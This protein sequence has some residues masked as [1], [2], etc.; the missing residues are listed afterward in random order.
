M[1]ADAAPARIGSRDHTNPH[2]AHVGRV[3]E[4]NPLPNMPR[5]S[6]AATYRRSAWLSAVAESVPRWT[7]GEER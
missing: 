6:A 1:Y 5:R 4:M 2:G 7:H 3:A